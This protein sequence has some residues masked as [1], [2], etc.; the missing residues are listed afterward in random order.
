MKLSYTWGEQE[1][2]LANFA[3]PLNE[4]QEH[5]LTR[6]VETIGAYLG[7]PS[8]SVW[9]LLQNGFSQ[10]LQ[11]AFAAVRAKAL[12]GDKDNAPIE[13]DSPEM[14]VLVHGAIG[15]RMHSIV[16][17]LMAAA[18]GG[19]RDPLRAVGLTMLEAHLA[20]KGKKLPKDKDA[21][22]LMLDRWIESTRPAIETE[23]R[24]RRAEETTEATL[25]D[26]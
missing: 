4:K 12:K 14:A 8:K 9:Y 11:D 18:P 19:G 13:A 20:A 24:R 25:D 21:R 5:A 10:S 15:K 23:I 17:G 26:L 2:A 3:E 6:G 1:Y 16:N 22:K 7:V